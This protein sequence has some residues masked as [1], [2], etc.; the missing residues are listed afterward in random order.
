MHRPRTSNGEQHMANNNIDE[1]SIID[2][3]KLKLAIK[4]LRL[5]AKNYKRKHEK[6][7]Y[8]KG[9]VIKTIITTKQEYDDISEEEKKELENKNTVEL[10]IELDEIID[11]IEEAIKWQ[12]K[13]PRLI[14][15]QKKNKDKWKK[16]ITTDQYDKKETIKALKELMSAVEII[17][18]KTG[19]EMTETDMQTKT[20]KE[21]LDLHEQALEIA[22]KQA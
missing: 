13:L 8:I 14:K 16:Q 1:I 18:E 3:T 10:M 7:E 12:R 17:E 19:K 4:M 5:R 11:D 22:E 20:N 9:D 2:Y 15:E 21:L 6:D